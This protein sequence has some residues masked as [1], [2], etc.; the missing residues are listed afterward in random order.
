MSSLQDTFA[1]LDHR[2]GKKGLESHNALLLQSQCRWDIRC[3]GLAT[4]IFGGQEMIARVRDDGTWQL[5]YLNMV[6]TIP[7]KDFDAAKR[8]ALG[9]AKRVLLSMLDLIAEGVATAAPDLH[10]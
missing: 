3:E 1:E 6:S 5:C 4:A 7:Y 9:F 10:Y 8:S 2:L